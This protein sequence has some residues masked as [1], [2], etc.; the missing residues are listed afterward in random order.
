M[1][2]NNWIEFH[3]VYVL[4]F[5]S[6]VGKDSSSLYFLSVVRDSNKHDW[7]SVPA[8]W[9]WVLRA[10]AVDLILAFWDFPQWFPVFHPPTE[11]VGPISLHPHQDSLSFLVFISFILTDIRWNLRIV[12]VCISLIAKNAEHYWTT[13]QMPGMEITPLKSLFWETQISPNNM[14]CFFCPLSFSRAWRLRP[15]CWR[16]YIL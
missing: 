6:S 7:A 14:D 13:I 4:H 8:V 16:Y 9:W 1:F 10:D 3:Y 2:F 11:N 12:S 5:Y 15:N